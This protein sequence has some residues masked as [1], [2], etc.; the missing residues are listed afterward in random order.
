[1]Q[2]NSPFEQFQN[3][4]KEIH[5]SAIKQDMTKMNELKD[6]AYKI[7]A[8]HFDN[9][10]SKEIKKQKSLD[11]AIKLVEYEQETLCVG[12]LNFLYAATA[13]CFLNANRF[14]EAVAYAQ[15]GIEANKFLKDEHG[16]WTNA[17]VLIDLG[18]LIG[19][20]DESVKLIDE[21]PEFSNK[22][23][24]AILT[25]NSPE[26]LSFMKMAL[27]KKERPASLKF[28]INKELANRE[29]MLRYSVKTLGVSRE[30]AEEDY[31]AVMAAKAKSAE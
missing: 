23:L 27:A 7:F 18:A 9:S 6:E 25:R 1:M 11:M 15:A 5:L 24:R 17:E 16:A 22:N 12:Y 26:G 8:T 10:E 20:C 3:D 14:M 2:S 28:C 30:E 13:R 21:Y 19:A 31:D 29:S 4:L